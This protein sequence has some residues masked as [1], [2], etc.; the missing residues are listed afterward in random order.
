M[1]SSCDGS[2][3]KRSWKGTADERPNK[4]EKGTADERPNKSENNCPD[5]SAEEKMFL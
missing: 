5:E 4:S 2:S 3:V 1:P